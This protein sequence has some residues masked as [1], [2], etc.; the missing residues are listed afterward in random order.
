[1]WSGGRFV[2]PPQEGVTAAR[3]K[4][5]SASKLPWYSALLPSSS[6]M[7]T[8]CPTGCS[9]APNPLIQ[10]D[11][12]VAG[13]AAPLEGALVGVALALDRAGLLLTLRL[14]HLLRVL[15]HLDHRNRSI[16]SSCALFDPPLQL[17]DVLVIE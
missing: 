12:E 16:P 15:H 8:S 11:A 1:L 3:L 17:G 2:P 10:Q 6:L 7:V 5:P 4:L 14:L 9:V 13:L